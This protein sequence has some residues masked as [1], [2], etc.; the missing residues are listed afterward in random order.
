[1][2]LQDAKKGEHLLHGPSNTV[3]TVVSGITKQAPMRGNYMYLG[4]KAKPHITV[5]AFTIYV[6]VTEE[7]LKEYTKTTRKTNDRKGRER[8]IKFCNPNTSFGF[9]TTK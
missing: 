5:R 3:W 1:M 9:P 6:H 2:K 4:I 7:Q 8:W